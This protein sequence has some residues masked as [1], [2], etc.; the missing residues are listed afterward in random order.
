MLRGNHGSRLCH[1]AGDTSTAGKAF[2]EMLAAFAEFETNQR[3]ERQ[4]EGIAAAT[5]RGIYK[6]RKPSIK[7]EAV[8]KLHAAGQGDT[9]SCGASGS[10]APACIGCSNKRHDQARYTTTSLRWQ[11]TIV[12]AA[13][14]R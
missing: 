13:I 3:K 7:M 2:L 4:L 10:R 8:Q 6:G 9:R 14:A 5:A 12:P 11:G 1:L